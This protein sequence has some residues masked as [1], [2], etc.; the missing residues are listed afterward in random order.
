MK[1]VE[2][3]CYLAKL[4]NIVIKKVNIV[5][6]ASTPELAFTDDELSDEEKLMNHTMFYESCIWELYMHGV[7]DKLESWKNLLHDYLNEYQGSWK[8]YAS[9][10]RMQSLRENG[11]EQA[12]FDDDGKIRTEGLSNEEL[13]YYTLKEQMIGDDVD[14]HDV[15]VKAY[16]S[17]LKHLYTSFTINSKIDISELI[18]VFTGKN[19]P[20]YTEDGNGNMV[21]MTFAQRMQQKALVDVAADEILKMIVGAA[22]EFRSMVDFLKGL[23]AFQDNRDELASFRNRIDRFMDLDFNMSEMA[24]L[25]YHEI[26]R[27]L[28]KIARK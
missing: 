18:R 16:P 13:E 4:F 12:D 3:T 5:R 2:D 10:R 20:L 28:E 25:A 14:V 11:A 22:Y 19:P 24:M 6:L 21:E 8:Y 26:L 23:D 15:A 7:M 9:S 27:T 17:D 1:R